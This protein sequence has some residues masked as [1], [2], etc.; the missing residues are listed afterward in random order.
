MPNYLSPGVYIEEVQAASR[1][2]EGVGHGRGGLRGPC[3]AR[4]R[5]HAGDGHELEPVRRLVRRLHGGV[6]P[7]AR[8]LRLLPQRRH[9]RLHRPDRRRRRRRPER[10]PG[11]A[12][13]HRQASQ[14]A[15]RVVAL[16]AGGA[17]NDINGRGRRAVRA[18]RGR[19]QAHRDPRLRRRRSTTTSPSSAAS[20]T[21]SPRSRRRSSSASRRSPRARSPRPSGRRSALTGGTRQRTRSGSPPTSTSATRPTGP[22]SAAW[23]PSRRSRWWPR[24]T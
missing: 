22:A 7:R 1:P 20:R 4:S 23:R 9:D 13:L 5:Q 8:G 6:V 21:S 18:R 14:P 19:L 16:E 11:A 24:P 10:P 3:P 15:F 2:I 17:G 12:E